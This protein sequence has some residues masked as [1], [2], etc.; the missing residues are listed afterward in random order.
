MAVEKIA[1]ADALPINGC[2]KDLFD[3]TCCDPSSE[4]RI[5]TGVLL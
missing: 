2:F 5:M 4:V 3:H 1:R